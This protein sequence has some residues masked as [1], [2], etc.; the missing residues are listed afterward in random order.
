MWFG[1]D[2]GRHGVKG[3]GPYAENTL[4]MP[5]YMVTAR[6]LDLDS[7]SPNSVLDHLDVTINGTRFF[8]GELARCNGGSRE[9]GKVKSDH[10]Y[11]IPLTLLAVALLCPAPYASIKLAV[12]LPISDYKTQAAGLEKRLVGEHV[13]KL[14][15][16]QVELEIPRNQVV[17]FPECAAAAWDLMLSPQ[18]KAQNMD[19]RKAT[20][21]VIDIGWKTV[22]F[23]VLR[24]LNYDDAA[25]GTLP[26]GL[27]QAFKYYYKRVVRERDLLPSQAELRLLRD[28]VPELKRLAQ[29]IR[30]SLSMWWP[31]LTE[32]DHVFLAGGGGE[33]LADYL[34]IPGARVLPDYHIANARGLYKICRANL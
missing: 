10:P 13:V 7:S 12:S 8:A 27:S 29:E 25:S 9:F 21:A 30:D 16:R 26:L 23:A 14:P 11:T 22:N 5:S 19:I 6:D 28:G 18:G 33:A 1:V 24:G 17:A 20:K 34:N 32:F 15:G 31:D 4:A 3:V 2:K